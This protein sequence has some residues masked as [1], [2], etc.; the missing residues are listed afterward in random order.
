M[1]RISLRRKKK[2]GG[3]TTKVKN[4]ISGSCITM[5]KTR[6]INESRSRPTE[7]ISRLMTCVAAAGPGDSGAMHSGEEGAHQS[8]QLRRRRRRGRQPRDELGRVPIG[9]KA[10][11]LIEQLGKNCALIVGNNVVADTRQHDAV[12]VRCKSF[13]REQRDRDDA[14]R[15]DSAQAAINVG[16]VDYVAD[17]PGTSGCA[18]RGHRHKREG[19]GVSAPVRQPLFGE[20]APDQGERAVTLVGGRWQTVIVRPPSVSCE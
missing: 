1:R 12:A 20:Q 6:P 3:A 19:A 7:G 16:L 5:T 2:A 4:D 9:E 11:A 14:K 15:D 13:G 18:P 17:E 10:K 8:E